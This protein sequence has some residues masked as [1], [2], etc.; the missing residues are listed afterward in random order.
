MWDH[1]P[2]VVT[3]AKFQNEISRGC[4]STEGRNFETA[5]FLLIFE[6]PL[7]QRSATAGA[8]CVI[9]RQDTQLKKLLMVCYKDEMF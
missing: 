8:A 4:D 7:E 2:Y 1:V 9:G 3:C 6:W 5:I